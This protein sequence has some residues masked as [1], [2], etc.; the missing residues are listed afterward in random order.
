MC[1]LVFAWQVFEGVPLVVAANRDE[2]MDR[3]STSPQ[4]I[5]E[6]PRVVAPRDEKAG[7][8]WIGIN[9][10]GVFAAITNRWSSRTGQRSRG[11]LVLDVL[12]ESSAE[13]AARLVENAVKSDHYAGFN[14]V[15]VDDRAAMYLTYNGTLA[16]Q[17]LQPG[18][19]VVVN[20]G[21]VPANS[22]TVG[23][24]GDTISIPDGRSEA[25]QTQAENARRL[26]EELQ[27]ISGER[28]ECW[29][30]RAAAAI[31]DHDFGV[32]I[33]DDGFGTR[34]SSLLSIRNDDVEYAYADGPPCLTEYDSIDVEF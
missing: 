12:A 3:P 27:P 33:H 2:A 17:P 15:L 13:S 25:G 22:A 32:C 29:R 20:V 28:P 34:S 19:F 8:T 26:S 7:G 23:H 14:L 21:L 16:V 6:E 30:E 24:G 5:N 10:H 11:L 9:E 4:L 1:T 31:R 18:V